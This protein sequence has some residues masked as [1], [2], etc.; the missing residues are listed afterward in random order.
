VG[1]HQSADQ[2][3]KKIDCLDDLK[4]QGMHLHKHQYT[5]IKSAAFTLTAADNGKIIL[6]DT[7]LVITLPSTGAAYGPFIIVNYGE[8][9]AATGISDVRITINPA[10]ADKIQGCG[11]TALA[12]KDLV[13]TLA[14]AKKGDY[15]KIFY[16]GT[17]AWSVGEMRGTWARE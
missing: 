11:I 3:V 16:G 2:K 1:Y 4:F 13:N 17:T 10:T 12:N 6:C 9:A 14:T 15:I 5:Q 7:T 8:E